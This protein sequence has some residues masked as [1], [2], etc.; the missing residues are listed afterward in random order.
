MVV[1]MLAASLMFAAIG[2]HRPKTNPNADP[3]A[4]SS[5]T[6][7]VTAD[8]TESA[9]ESTEAP[10][11]EPTEKPDPL[12]TYDKNDYEALRAFFELRDEDGVRNGEK[13]FPNYDP[14]D[15]ATWMNTD[16]YRYNAVEWDDSGK[17]SYL[18]FRGTEESPIA[19]VG[20][21]D[22]N[23]LTAIEGVDSWM[24][25]FEE[26]S[27]SDLPVTAKQNNSCFQF[28]M[29]KGEASF[30]GGYIERLYML[31]ASHVFCD[32]TGDAISDLAELP[33]FKVDLTIEGEGCAGITAY[34][35]EHY[36][37]V[38]LIADPAEG[39]TFVGWFDADGKL[40]SADENYTLYGEDSGVSSKG[41]HGEFMLT[42]HFE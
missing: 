7:Q 24:A 8:S 27:A 3:I 30:T 19:L 37:E 41:A 21:L 14:D 5:S 10:T 2:C 17:A 33:S 39:R 18:T 35:D 32:I 12:G 42:A 40:I 4:E 31:S 26:I 34:G 9:T 15:P 20:K 36:Y 16:P 11:S 38:H 6:E 23:L 13:C 1:F 29:V 25:A 28:P 22:L